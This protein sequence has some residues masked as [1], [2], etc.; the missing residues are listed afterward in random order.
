[1][2]HVVYVSYLGLI[3]K[4]SD[5]PLLISLDNRKIWELFVSAEGRGSPHRHHYYGNS[6]YWDPQIS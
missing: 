6:K 4:K 2:V 1:M 5:F 3:L